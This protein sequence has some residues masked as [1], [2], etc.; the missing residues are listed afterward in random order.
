MST[1]FKIYRRPGMDVMLFATKA[2]AT[3]RL[4]AIMLEHNLRTDNKTPPRP[5]LAG[6]ANTH[7]W[8]CPPSPSGAG[9][10]VLPRDMGY[11]VRRRLRQVEGQNHVKAAALA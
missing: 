6:I 10:F 2:D 8:Q 1:F 4:Q 7:P 9:T 11:S 3:R 5:G